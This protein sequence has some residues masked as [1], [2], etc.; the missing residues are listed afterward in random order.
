MVDRLL[1]LNKEAGKSE[2]RKKKSK[3][4]MTT[5]AVKENW[6][7]VLKKIKNQVKILKSPATELSQSR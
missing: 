2:Q 3:L 6:G 1:S 7:T 5:N 4:F